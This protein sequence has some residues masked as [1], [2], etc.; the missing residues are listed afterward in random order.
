MQTQILK[1][2]TLTMRQ[3][4]WLFYAFLLFLVGVPM[5]GLVSGYKCYGFRNTECEMSPDG[6]YLSVQLRSGEETQV[7]VPTEKR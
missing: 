4:G 2:T 5:S 6:K 7:A 1:I 3:S